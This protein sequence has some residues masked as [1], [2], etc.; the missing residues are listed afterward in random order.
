MNVEQSNPS[1]A[2]VCQVCHTH[3]CFKHIYLNMS[4]ALSIPMWQRYHTNSHVAQVFYTLAHP[5]QQS[6][7]D[8]A[9]I[10]NHCVRPYNQPIECAICQETDIQQ[11]CV[12]VVNCK[13][14]FH[15][16]CISKWILVTCSNASSPTCPLCRGTIL[17]KSISQSFYCIYYQVVIQEYKFLFIKTAGKGIQI[18]LTSLI[19]ILFLKNLSMPPKHKRTGTWLHSMITD[20]R[21]RGRARVLVNVFI[22]DSFRFMRT[23]TFLFATRIMAWGVWYRVDCSLGFV[24]SLIIDPSL[25]DSSK[26]HTCR[27]CSVKIKEY[28][29]GMSIVQRMCVIAGG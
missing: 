12:E 27:V 2:I 20:R 10:L 6:V 19:Y 24:V 8:P 14:K 29:N 22:T 1:R 21:R 16:E 7:N 18:V 28:D 15:K 3:R 9:M 25:K 17:W 23:R 11:Q 13:H 4:T 26:A 5:Q